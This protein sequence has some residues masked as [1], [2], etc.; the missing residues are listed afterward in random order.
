VVACCALQL[1]DTEPLRD[2]LSVLTRR[3]VP[4][5]LEQ[6]EWQTRMVHAAAVRIDP[7]ML[8]AGP[9]EPAVA[10]FEL[11]FAALA[12]DRPVNSVY[13][14]RLRIDCAADAASARTGPWRN[15][16]LYVFLTGEPAGAPPGWSPAG[17]TCAPFKLGV[18][19]LGLKPAP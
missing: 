12:A 2:R 8:C 4:R 15:D 7:P 13:N 14:P 18:W 19:C 17:L 1:I 9:G 5:L 3:D 11:Q 6:D 10:N 16:T